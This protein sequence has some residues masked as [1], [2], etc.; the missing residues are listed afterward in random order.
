MEKTHWIIIL[1]FVSLLLFTQCHQIQTRED[2]IIDKFSLIED[3]STQSLVISGFTDYYNKAWSGD[4]LITQRVKNLHRQDTITS[5][6]KIK[7]NLQTMSQLRILFDIVRIDQDS[8]RMSYNGANFFYLSGV[9]RSILKWSGANID[10]A[11]NYT[12]D[13]F[14]HL[15]ITDPE[16]Y[17]KMW[18][19]YS[20]LYENEEQFHF[21][22]DFGPNIYLNKKDYSLVRVTESSEYNGQTQYI[23]TIIKKQEYN[24]VIG[25]DWLLY[26]RFLPA[27]YTVIDY[28]LEEPKTYGIG[29]G[30]YAP[31]IECKS[32]ENQDFRL[33]SYQDQ[34]V[35]LDFWYMTCV[36]CKK[37]IPSLLEID[38]KY[39]E[40]QI[41]GINPVDKDI[42]LL[43][44][45]ISENKIN[46]IQ[47]H[48]IDKTIKEK[49][50]VVLFPTLVL[51][52]QEGKIVNVYNGL[53]SIQKQNLIFKIDSLL[54]TR[55]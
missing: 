11:K 44:K 43:R 42:F 47:I 51:I 21:A 53:D 41:V 46:F 38:E 29:K 31:E 49:Y 17:A 10:V 7:Y 19:K 30:N 24:K 55:R 52:D 9:N 35:L 50:N 28:S 20:S 1:A 25:S 26:E 12:Y 40:V 36:P 6:L 39:N 5:H 37:S 2:S 3:S 16:E 22:D 4:L 8:V 14:M 27:G 32:T 23:E 48:D 34:I 18:M 33:S 13:C 45:Y 15:P 54:K